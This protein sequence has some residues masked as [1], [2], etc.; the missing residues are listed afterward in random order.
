MSPQIFPA[1]RRW[2]TFAPVWNIETNF[3]IFPKMEKFCPSMAL[4]WSIQVS[5][6]FMHILLGLVQ[7][8]CLSL[9]PVFL[10]NFSVYWKI[11]PN[12]ESH[13]STQNPN[14]RSYLLYPGSRQL[15]GCWIAFPSK[16]FKILLKNLPQ[17]VVKF[18]HKTLLCGFLTFP[19]FSELMT[20][21]WSL[22]GTTLS[23]LS[24]CS[25]EPSA[26]ST[27]FLMVVALP[28][29]LVCLLIFRSRKN[30]PNVTNKINGETHGQIKG[31]SHVFH[32]FGSHFSFRNLSRIAIQNSLFPGFDTVTD[33]G[34]SANG[35]HLPGWCG[36]SVA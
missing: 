17:C 25:I 9:E 16:F 12:M 27:N 30:C 34:G 26:L 21:S 8:D 5:K 7:T 15:P 33:L 35:V 20:C 19:I 4:P 22:G 6:L 23:W 10:H 14:F 24:I 31:L 32:Q 11:C 13:T 29:S 3:S 18:N 1:S 28:W 36:S 2:K